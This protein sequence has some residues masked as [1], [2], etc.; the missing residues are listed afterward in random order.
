MTRR[1]VLLTAWL[2]CCA[3]APPAR[4][5][6]EGPGVHLTFRAARTS[7]PVVI[8]GK[9]DEAAWATAEPFSDFV[10]RYPNPGAKPTERTSFR[11]LYDDSALYVAVRCYD[12]QPELINRQRGRRDQDVNTDA[13]QVLI[14]ASHDHRTAILLYVGAGGTQVDGF[15]YDDSTYTA[16]WDAVWD[17]ASGS[18]EG[19]S[20]RRAGGAA[21]PAPLPRG[22]S[23][24]VGL[25]GSPRHPPKGRGAGGRL[26]PALQQRFRLADGPPHRDG[27]A[28]SPS[29]PGAAALSGCARAAPPE[30]P[31]SGTPSA[32]PSL[33]LRRRRPGRQLRALQPPRAHRHPQPGFRPG[34]GRS[35]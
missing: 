19:G 33:P 8:D 18:F 23:A 15:V 35:A 21:P 31:G 6:L 25:L 26:Q 3:L 10:Q 7:E 24:D 16:D 32:A 17:G 29:D 11:V 2:F 12:S 14:D 30:V 20:D 34:G 22:S 1:F 4:A 9:L 27:G 28:A 5:A 13:I